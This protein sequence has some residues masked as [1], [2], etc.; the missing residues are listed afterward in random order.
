ML[1][2]TGWKNETRKRLS[3]APAS[4]PEEGDWP[5]VGDVNANRWTDALTRLRRAHEQL[6]AAVR[7]LPESTLYKATNDPRDRPLGAGVLYYVLLHGIVQHDVY[8]AG[9]IAILKKA[10]G[11]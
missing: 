11:L 7:Q 9:Q 1:H 4:L 6:V 2:V 8:H 3:G 10:L 5:E